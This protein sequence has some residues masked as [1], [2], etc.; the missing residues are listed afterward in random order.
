MKEEFIS[1]KTPFEFIDLLEDIR[2][3]D[4]LLLN[5]IRDMI[6][7]NL[8]IIYDPDYDV[9][10]ALKH[11]TILRDYLE[12]FISKNKIYGNIEDYLANIIN[13]CYSIIET[14]INYNFK[15]V[16]DEVFT[17]RRIDVSSTLISVNKYILQQ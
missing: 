2:V 1:I 17:I 5:L 3:I 13:G 11:Q 6:V 4:D 9:N 16:L 15:F 14:L 7:I 8:N 12:R 10:V